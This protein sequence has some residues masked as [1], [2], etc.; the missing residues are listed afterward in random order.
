[1]RTFM[2]K[3]FF[4]LVLAATTVVFF[5]ETAFCQ[6]KISLGD[7]INVSQ[8]E[9]VK[10]VIK[11]GD[12]RPQQNFLDYF[13]KGSLSK[14]SKNKVD[15]KN[16][17]RCVIKFRGKLDVL[18][19]NQNQYTLL[20]TAPSV[21]K[22][23]SCPSG[24][25]LVL[26]GDKLNEFKEKYDEVE[27]RISKKKELVENILHHETKDSIRLETPDGVLRHICVGDEIH[28]PDSSW[29]D[30]VNQN[31]IDQVF[32]NKT[33]KISFGDSCITEIGGTISIKGFSDN[34]K[35]TIAEYT[36]PGDALGTSCP[37]K[38]LLFFESS[39][40]FFFEDRYEEHLKKLKI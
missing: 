11:A 7:V 10:V 21:S 37:D 28:I 4:Y 9:W 31:Q 35:I 26:S 17:D 40:L 39:Q 19:V 8:N 30:I 29:F 2:I 34:E 18:E 13:S 6:K 5:Q 32:S 16:G 14:P 24:I 3:S 20:Y 33:I 15:M 22:G 23:T 12:H 27:Q 38:S 25:K 36:P 1:M